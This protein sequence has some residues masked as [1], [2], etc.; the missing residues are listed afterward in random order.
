MSGLAG[1]RALVDIDRSVRI[2]GEG[3]LLFKDQF[4]LEIPLKFRYPIQ[5]DTLVQGKSDRD[6]S[7]LT[8]L[9][10]A[11]QYCTNEHSMMNFL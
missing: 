9:V 2:V 8:D 7:L 5:L 1:C 11:F 3:F 6:P 10:P 4:L